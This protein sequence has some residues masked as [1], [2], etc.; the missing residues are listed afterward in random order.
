MPWR[1]TH[2]PWHILVSEI[3]LQQTQIPRVREI[4]P[5]FM[6]R[7]P[8]PQHMARVPLR[9]VLAMWQGMG[10]NRRAKF[11]HDTALYIVKNH[12]GHIP[13][14]EEAL[15]AL[16]GIGPYSARAIACFAYGICEPFIETN[17]RRAIIHE[18]F[19]K[20]THVDDK[21]I[22]CILERIQPRKNLRMW[23]LALMDYGR[24]ALKHTPNP[25][26]RSKH[27][28]KQ[29]KFEGSARQLRAAILRLLLQKK[30]ATGVQL[31]ASLT[32]T[33][34]APHATEDTLKVT[35]ANLEKERLI[36]KSG[37]YY[38]VL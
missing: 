7:F 15:R 29:S 9:T 17:I 20:E 34:E 27:Y 2:D 23:Y 10:Y 22:L 31:L 8:T 12:N 14:T 11:L 19:Q 33:A 18:F 25:N 26:R 4:Y 5:A 3:M 38:R 24:D 16:P 28:T 21:D 13:K 1:T 35:L 6:R 36:G 30:K 37:A 32:K